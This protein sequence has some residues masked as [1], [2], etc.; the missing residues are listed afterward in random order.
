MEIESQRRI[1]ERR[2]E[3]RQNKVLGGISPAGK[4]LGYQVQSKDHEH[5]VAYKIINSRY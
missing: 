3:I 5:T 4:L 2:K 1:L